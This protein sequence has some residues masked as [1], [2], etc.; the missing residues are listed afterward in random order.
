MK[1]CTVNMRKGKF[2]DGN[3][4]LKNGKGEEGIFLEF[5]EEDPM[6][7]EAVYDQLL[8]HWRQF[9]AA[10]KQFTPALYMLPD[11]C[12]SFSLCIMSN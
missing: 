3:A 11:D 12:E 10:L 9:A 7:S 5:G 4:Y 2:P 8:P 1:A 6:Y